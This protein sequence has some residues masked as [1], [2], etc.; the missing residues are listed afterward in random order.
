MNAPY[1]TI[2]DC[3]KMLNLIQQEY[4]SSLLPLEARVY[5]D[6]FQISAIHGD[7]AR[8]STFARRAYDARVV[9][10]GDDSPWAV[11][12]KRSIHSPT[13]HQSFGVSKRWSTKKGIVPKGLDEKEFDEWLWKRGAT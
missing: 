7:Q 2:A 5:Y 10:E 4:D 9:G 11:R 1:R 8:A 13:Q 12:M 3:Q 6:A